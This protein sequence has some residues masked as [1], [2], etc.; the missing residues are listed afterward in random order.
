MTGLPPATDAYV[1]VAAVDVGILNLTNYKAPDPEAWFFG[2]RQLGLELRDLYGRLIDGSLGA[3]GKLRT[4][5]D[6]AQMADER[7]PADREAGR[8]L[9]RPGEARRRGQGDV[10]FD[11]PQF[12]GTVRVMAVAWTKDAVGHATSDV[13]VR[14]PIV[15]T[16]SLP[17][18]LTPGDKA[19]AAARYRQYRRPG[20]RLHAGAGVRRH[21]RR[22]PTRTSCARSRASARR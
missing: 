3:T 12:N 8:L 21:R 11:I 6:G 7:Q 1:M 13:I 5:G 14:D 2:Q 19:A 9:L 4:G 16:A 18:F 10:D 22:Q 17:R 15:V 20:R